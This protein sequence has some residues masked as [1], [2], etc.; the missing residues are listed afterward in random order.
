MAAFDLTASNA[1]CEAFDYD[2]GP[3]FIDGYRDV[4]ESKRGDCDDFNL[5]VALIVCGGWKNLIRAL[6]RGDVKFHLA[7]SAKNGL[8][9]RHSVLE[10]N[11]FFIDSTPAKGKRDPDWT[12]GETPHELVLTMPWPWVLFRAAWGATLGRIFN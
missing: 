7:R 3:V 9:P 6:V 8:I 10:I 11:G 12:H 1:F 4:R 2:K 5:A